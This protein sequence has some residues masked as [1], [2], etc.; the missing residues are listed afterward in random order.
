MFQGNLVG[1]YE[2][3]HC[4]YRHRQGVFASP[5]QGRI[6]FRTDGLQFEER[7]AEMRRTYLETHP[8]ISEEQRRTVLAASATPGMT[9]EELST[10]WGLA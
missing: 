6:F 10:A 8:E 7:R 5:W 2:S 9:R 3:Q 1:A 4:R